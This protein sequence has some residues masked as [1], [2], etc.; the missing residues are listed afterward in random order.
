MPGT[1]A[2]QHGHVQLW[3]E[4]GSVMPA[5]APRSLRLRWPPLPQALGEQLMQSAPSSGG[6]DWVHL[7]LIAA[8]LCSPRDSA[9]L[10]HLLKQSSVNKENSN[11]K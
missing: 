7:P 8:V 2:G 11:N 3:G 5:V 1:R 10:N 4:L 6:G 9:D